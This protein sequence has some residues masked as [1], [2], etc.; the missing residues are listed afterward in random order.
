MMLISGTNAE[1]EGEVG[2]PLIINQ[3]KP[4]PIILNY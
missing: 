4:P 1:A 2:N 3:V